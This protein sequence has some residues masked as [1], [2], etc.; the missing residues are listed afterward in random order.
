LWLEFK[1]NAVPYVL[2]LLAAAFYF[3]TVRT[4]G[5]YPPVWTVRASVITNDMV[6]EFGAFAA[7]LA[8]WAGSREGRRKTGDLVA[9]TPRA[10]W[11][12]QSVALAGT[13]GWMLLAFLAGVAVLYIQTA[14]QATWG[15]PP[16]WPVFVGVAGVT[17]T[18]VIGFAAG[19]FFPGRFT[20]PL[21][22]ILVFVLSQVGFR[23]ALDLTP[24]SGT[25]ALLSPSTSVPPVDSGVYYHVAPDLSIVQV[26]FMGGIALALFGV[27]GLASGLR[28]RASAGGLGSLRA[29]FTRGD[30]WVLRAAAVVLIAGGVASAATAFSLAGTARPDPVAGTEQG[31]G[32]ILG[33]E[34]PALHAVTA[35]SPFGEAERATGRWLP[36]LRLLTAVGLTGLAIGLLQLGV[37]GESLND[38]VLVLARNVIGFTGLGLACSLV[39]GG[40]LAWTLPLGYMVFC[41]YALLEAWRAPWAWPVRSPADRG[42]W[43]CAS[44]VLAAGLLL[45]TVRGPRTHLSDNG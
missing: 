34:I 3:N 44:V 29:W 19:V 1:R 11:A 2:P 16:L 20:A 18:T 24:A 45:F 7:G 41:Q 37:A 32:A 9:T 40:L 17:V 39:T 36:Y 38:G 33:W 6:L 23:E 27:L 42:A 14:L 21:A 25:Y 10:V 12:R 5:G 35:Q 15:G 13:L 26:M 8:A 4:A 43:I 28:E 22:A 30:G 31:G